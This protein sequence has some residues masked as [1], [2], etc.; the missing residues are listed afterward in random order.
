MPI[1]LRVQFLFVSPQLQQLRT[2]NLVFFKFQLTEEMSNYDAKKT[3]QVVHICAAYH[4]GPLDYPKT[5]SKA[6]AD[7]LKAWNK[8]FLQTQRPLEKVMA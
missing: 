7:I 8:C 3:I 5:M 1:F 6:V 4:G 2:Y